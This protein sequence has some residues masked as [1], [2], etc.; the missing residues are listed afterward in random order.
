M[1]IKSSICMC[2]IH[3]LIHV[4]YTL[5]FGASISVQSPKQ[6]TLTFSKLYE[7]KDYLG[8]SEKNFCHLLNSLGKLLT[9]KIVNIL[10]T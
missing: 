10:T 2:V 1:K 8:D 7:S 9:L 6:L 5:M 3:V 4:Q